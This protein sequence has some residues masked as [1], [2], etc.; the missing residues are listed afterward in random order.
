MILN[1][2]TAVVPPLPQVVAG[3]GHELVAFLPV[4]LLKVPQEVFSCA[5]G[6]LPEVLADRAGT[7][8]LSGKPR[9]S[10]GVLV[11]GALDLF[12]CEGC[13]GTE[14]R[15]NRQTRQRRRGRH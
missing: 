7:A 11:L 5:P 15:Q 1:E 14:A 6:H 9:E 12:V 10:Q 3:A 13:L 4:G 8:V 2:T